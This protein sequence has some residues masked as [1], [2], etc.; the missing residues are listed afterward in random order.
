MTPE[1]RIKTKK[2]KN[3]SNVVRTNAKNFIILTQHFII[4]VRKLIMANFHRV[5]YLTIKYFKAQQKIEAD[6]E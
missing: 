5:H 6:Q 3:N 1:M 4:I 2:E